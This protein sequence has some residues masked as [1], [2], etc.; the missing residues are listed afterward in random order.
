MKD[1]YFSVHVNESSQEY[2][3]FFC[4]LLVFSFFGG[5]GGGGGGGGGGVS[6]TCSQ[7]FPMG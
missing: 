7:P 2:L 1:S 6:F 5:W 4:F 3:K